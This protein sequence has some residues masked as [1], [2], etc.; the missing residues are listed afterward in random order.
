MAGSTACCQVPGEPRGTPAEQEHPLDRQTCLSSSTSWPR[1]LFTLCLS[2]SA[3]RSCSC[4]TLASR[5]ASSRSRCISARRRCTSSAWAA[6]SPESCSASRCF[7]WALGQ[8]AEHVR[9]VAR[10][11][12]ISPHLPSVR[13]HAY[14]GCCSAMNLDTPFP[15]HLFGA[16]SLWYHLKQSSGLGEQLSRTCHP[17]WSHA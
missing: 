17:T 3:S 2:S 14:S 13:A 6:F 8:W 15:T 12:G 5:A 7:S 9:R 11:K 16:L 1:Q 4:W 10:N